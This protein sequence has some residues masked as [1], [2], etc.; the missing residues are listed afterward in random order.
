MSADMD[1]IF[2][3]VGGNGSEWVAFSARL[4]PGFLKGQGTSPMKGNDSRSGLWWRSPACLQASVP[5]IQYLRERGYKVSGGPIVSQGYPAWGQAIG[6][7]LKACSESGSHLRVRA[8]PAHGVSSPKRVKCRHQAEDLPAV[9]E[10]S[11][12]P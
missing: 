9:R 3:A 8:L 10:S 6:A 5:G 7:V 2:E 11:Q 12:A 1:L 4:R